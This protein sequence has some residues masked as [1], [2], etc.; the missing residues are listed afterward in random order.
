VQVVQGQCRG[1]FAYRL[2]PKNPVTMRVA[3][4]FSAQVQALQVNFS[5]SSE[6]K[7]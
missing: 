7:E 1:K 4:R 6:K 2:H 5:T 3:G